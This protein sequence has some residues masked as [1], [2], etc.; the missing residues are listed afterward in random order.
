MGISE[1]IQREIN[2]AVDDWQNAHKA[3][4]ERLKRIEGDVGNLKSDMGNKVPWAWFLTTMVAIGGIQVTLWIYLI[5]QIKEV[6]ED[7]QETK[8]TVYEI[9]GK[10]E[11]F[12]FIVDD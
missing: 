12:D 11:P 1:D 10:L 2:H 8:N 3:I 6:K 5:N 7:Q 4:D 9:N